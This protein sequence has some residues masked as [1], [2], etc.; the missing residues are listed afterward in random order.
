MVYLNTVLQNPGRINCSELVQILTNLYHR[1]EPACVESCSK[2]T[3][4]GVLEKTEDSLSLP[5]YL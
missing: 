5:C 3:A 4:G 2:I 1:Q